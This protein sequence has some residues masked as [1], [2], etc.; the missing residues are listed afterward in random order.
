MD[1]QITL[2]LNA[3]CMA[4]GGALAYLGLA[5]EAVALLL[6]LM[7]IDIVTGIVKSIKLGDEVTTKK[8][9]SGVYAKGAG[10]TILM[11]GGLT[12]KA[13]LVAFNLEP[14]LIGYVLAPFVSLAVIGELYSAG[15]NLSLAFFGQRL[16]EWNAWVFMLKLIKEKVEDFFR[17]IAEN[18]KV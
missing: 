11:T 18:M 4:L 14:S 2:A 6:I 12:V 5:G 8:W 7:V 17:K 10:I 9:L 3:V 13:V 1:I 16:P 15:A